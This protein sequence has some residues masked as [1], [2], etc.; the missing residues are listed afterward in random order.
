VIDMSTQIRMIVAYFRTLMHN[1]R[2]DERG[3]VTETVAVTALLV[4][5]ALAVIAIIVVKVTQ[6]ANGISL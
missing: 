2:T 6:K 5:L 4:A 3:Y 1:L